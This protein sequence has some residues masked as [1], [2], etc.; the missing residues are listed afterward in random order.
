MGSGSH[1]QRPRRGDRVIGHR[2]TAARGPAR[3]RAA[4]PSAA[5]SGSRPPAGPNC[6][7][8]SSAASQSASRS[9]SPGRRP[10]AS[11]SHRPPSRMRRPTPSPTRRSQ[12]ITSSRTCLRDSP[13][14]THSTA[15]VHG[16]HRRRFVSSTGG[17]KIREKKR[18]VA[19]GDAGTLTRTLETAVLW[20]GAAVY[21]VSVVDD[22]PKFPDPPHGSG[23][24]GLTTPSLSAQCSSQAAG[25]IPAGTNA[26]TPP[27]ARSP[28]G[29][30]PQAIPAKAESPTEPRPETCRRQSRSAC[31]R[32][33]RPRTGTGPG[34]GP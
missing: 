1:G 33:C 16:P 27:D 19:S 3:V 22:A 34:P 12:L 29:H 31:P 11:S 5:R 18:G 28:L 6:G 10:A 25:L 17:R 15:L 13:W 30:R 23:I 14:L 8:S 4:V 24:P 7:A 20:N 2:R 26:T 9:A 21:T 32:P